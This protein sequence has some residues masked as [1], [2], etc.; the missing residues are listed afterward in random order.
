MQVAAI[1]ISSFLAVIGLYLTHNLRRQ[2][3]LKIAQQRVAA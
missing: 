1:I 2:Q 3:S